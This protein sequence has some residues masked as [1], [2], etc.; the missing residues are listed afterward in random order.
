MLVASV[1]RQHVARLRRPRC[2]SSPFGCAHLLHPL[3]KLRLCLC[4]PPGLLLHA[5]SLSPGL[6]RHLR[7]LLSSASASSPQAST[8]RGSSHPLHRLTVQTELHHHQ[9]AGTWLRGGA[10]VGAEAGQTD[11][12]APSRHTGDAD[13]RTQETD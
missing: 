2:T 6:P 13:Q 4:Q 10:G 11:G 7:P 3:A 12:L 9:H 1:Q 5:P 8:G